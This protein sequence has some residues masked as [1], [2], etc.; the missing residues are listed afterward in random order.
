MKNEYEK[1]SLYPDGD[2]DRHQNLIICSWARCQMPTFRE[3]F[4]QIR[5]EFIAYICQQTERQAN[6]QRQKHNHLGGGKERYSSANR[7]LNASAAAT[8]CQ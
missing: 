4:M 1:Q 2:P 5:S 8:V 3:N 6:K 7:E